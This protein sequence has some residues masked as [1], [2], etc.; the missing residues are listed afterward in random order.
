MPT[1]VGWAS[2]W[3]AHGGVDVATVEDDVAG[4]VARIRLGLHG[5]RDLGVDLVRRKVYGTAALGD[6]D[7]DELKEV[8]SGVGGCLEW[9]DWLERRRRG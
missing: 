1:Y 7:A 6:E 5:V 8:E 9:R 2:R 3:R 4:A